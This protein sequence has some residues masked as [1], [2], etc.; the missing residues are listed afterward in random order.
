M[1]NPVLEPGNRR[2]CGRRGLMWAAIA[3]A[4]AVPTFASEPD[5]GSGPPGLGRTVDDLLA[6]ARQMNPEIRVRVLT[7]EAAEARIVAAGALPDPMLETELR[8]I[9]GSRRS[10]GAAPERI[11]RVDYRISQNFP[12]WGKRGL[13]RE[14][15]EADAATARQ[16]TRATTIGLDTRIKA[17]FAEYYAAHQA[18][19]LVDRLAAT[20][21]TIAD[22]ARQRYT[23]G[24]VGQR[25]A[26]AAAVERSRLDSDRV[27][28]LAAK[29]RGAARLNGLLNRPPGA[30]LAD[31]EGLRPLP[32][33][34]VLALA[35]LLARAEAA[36]P[37][38]AAQRSAITA[39]EANQRLAERTWYPDLGV[40]LTAFEANP[41]NGSRRFEGYE[42]MLFSE[43]PLQWEARRAGQQ[44]ATISAAAARARLE[45]AQAR[46]RADLEDALLALQGAIEA[47]RLLDGQTLPRA[48]AALASVQTAYS[49]GRAELTEVLEAGQAL[50]R[51]DLDRLQL[52]VEQQASLAVIEQMSGGPL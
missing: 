42:V 15:A 40:R 29:R 11:N 47:E 48:R 2:R 10:D 31:P 16:E 9:T 6:Y 43:I 1:P 35:P 46:L 37:E 17:V 52:L 24:S 7:A 34:E 49:L 23:L 30:F 27:L 14:A 19:A 44:D 12:L 5:P 21:D 8:D 33:A 41:G 32:S 20:T 28:R 50:R 38:L 45:A 25:D 26:I 39:A 51:L 18:V 4:L 22:A 3:A 13:R 36:N